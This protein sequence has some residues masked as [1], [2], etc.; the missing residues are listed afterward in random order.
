MIQAARN[1]FPSAVSVNQWILWRAEPV[2][3]PLASVAI[4]VHR[5]AFSTALYPPI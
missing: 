3:W 2:L 1:G 5:A 4:N